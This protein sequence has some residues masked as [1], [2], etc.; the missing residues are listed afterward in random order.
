MA[1]SLPALLACGGMRHI[2]GT[3]SLRAPQPTVDELEWA[4]RAHGIKTI[5]CL[6]APAAGQPWYDAEVAACAR[7]GVRHVALG[8]SAL[9]TDDDRIEAFIDVLNTCD[10]PVLLH[11]RSGHD[12][13]S[14][15]AAIYRRVVLGH[16]PE[17]AD[18]ELDFV[19]HGHVPLFGYEAMDD[20]WQR[21]LARENAA[22]AR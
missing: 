18:D 9:G 6:R 2:A 19:P 13:T 11:C 7:L 21:F 15:A 4:I 3:K 20:A 10:G 14:L 1:L 8:W 22:A 17:D 16:D 5:I 12:R